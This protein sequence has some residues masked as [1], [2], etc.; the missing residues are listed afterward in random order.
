MLR[1][2]GSIFTTLAPAIFAGI[3]NM[4]WV[5]SSVG[6]ALKI[7][8]DRGNKLKDGRRLFGDNKT[9]KGFWGMVGLGALS[10]LVWGVFLKGR[11]LEDYNLLHQVFANTP[12]WSTIS[13][14]LL[15]LGYATAELPNSFLKRRLAISPGKN[16]KG[17]LRPFFIFLDQADSVLGCLIVLRIFY[18]YGWNF[19]IIGLLIGAATH[20]LLNILLYFMNLRKNMF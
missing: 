13:G 9:W 10:G 17:F 12:L 15:G 1:I 3:L 20:I 8:M 7:P 14:A 16:P 4:I 6:D 19:F 5:S 18:P 2:I 11:P